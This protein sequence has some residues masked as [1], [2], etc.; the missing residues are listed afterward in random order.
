MAFKVVIYRQML[1][2]IGQFGHVLFPM[3]FGHLGQDHPSNWSV[4]GVFSSLA[5][6]ISHLQDQPEN[7]RVSKTTYDPWVDPPSWYGFFE[8]CLLIAAEFADLQK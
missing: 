7:T 4:T 3:N 8:F 6:G 2:I 1:L 5:N